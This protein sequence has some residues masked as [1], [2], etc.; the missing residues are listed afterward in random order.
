MSLLLNIM[1]G[2]LIFG[3]TGV[4][5][6]AML[7]YALIA[8]FIAG[9]MVG[10]TPEYVGKKLESKEVRMATLVILIMAFSILSLSAIA[11]VDA[12]RAGRPAQ[13]GSARLLR[14]HL[15]V[16]VGDRQQRQ[17]LRRSRGEHASSTT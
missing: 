16:H 8:V 11:V 4:G 1:L 7:V 15:R 12:G 5:L 6:V 13:P 3:G 14:D 10:R 9:L 17:R 2:E